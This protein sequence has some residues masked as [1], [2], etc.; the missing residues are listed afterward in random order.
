MSVLDTLRIVPRLILSSRA[1]ARDL[2]TS[3]Y[4]VVS[5]V[6]GKTANSECSELGLGFA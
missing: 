5:V 3:V 1:I 2:K 4:A 6:G